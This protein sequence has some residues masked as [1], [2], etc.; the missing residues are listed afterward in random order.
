MA[1]LDVDLSE[2]AGH[3]AKGIEA[4]A[5]VAPMGLVVTMCNQAAELCPCFPCARSQIHW[6]FPDPASTMSTEQERVQVF[7]HIRD[8]IATR[9]NLSLAT[10]IAYEP[11]AGK[12]IPHKRVY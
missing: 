11:A 2:R 4:F 7:R 9:I 8:L 1:E 6:G 12:P 10:R 3:Y 5:H